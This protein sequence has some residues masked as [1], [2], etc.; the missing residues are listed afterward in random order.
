MPGAG[1]GL[2]ASGEEWAAQGVAGSI[3]AAGEGATGGDGRWW[4]EVEDGAAGKCKRWA[5]PEEY[6]SA[7]AAGVQ[8]TNY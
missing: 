2:V 1:R 8:E 4:E 6:N 7:K 3:E 5:G